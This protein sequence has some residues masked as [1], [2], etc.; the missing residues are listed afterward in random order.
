MSDHH[1]AEAKEF[2]DALLA[3]REARE[4]LFYLSR[5]AAEEEYPETEVFERPVEIYD[6]A[7]LRLCHAK[8][9]LDEAKSLDP[10]PLCEECLKRLAP[11]QITLTCPAQSFRRPHRIKELA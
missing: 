11:D 3:V 4:K 9:A 5:E 6:R 2:A 7:C 8:D 1:G 10:R